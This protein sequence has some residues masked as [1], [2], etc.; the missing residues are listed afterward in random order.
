MLSATVCSGHSGVHSAVTLGR[1]GYSSLLEIGHEL[2]HTRYVTAKTVLRAVT[3]GYY[4]N[5]FN[6]TEILK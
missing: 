3:F 2:C 5:L 6:S 4:F 1:E